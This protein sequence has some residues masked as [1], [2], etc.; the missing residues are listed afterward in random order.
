MEKYSLKNVRQ[1]YSYW[2]KSP[3]MYK[4]ASFVAFF[5]KENFLRENAVAN[6]KLRP[7]DR[8][9]DL[10]C[11]RGYNFS[12]LMDKIGNN[13]MIIGVDYVHEM[14]NV[15]KKRMN[16]KGWD[17]IRIIREDAAK[18]DFPK[19]YFDG[20]ISTLGISAIPDHKEALKRAVYSLK[21]KKRLVILDGKSF[22]GSYKILNPLI[23]CT[24]WSESWDK[25]KNIIT[26][27]K[28]LL[29]DVVIEE[30]SG[31]SFFI[32]TGVKR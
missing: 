24:R 18:I 5:G 32:L 2:G 8:V 20:V 10:A 13:G 3:G 17:S 14:L 9:L 1:V 7:G 22:N 31:G 29:N 25:N 15:A 12:Y 27:A 26:D 19:N 16:E 21:N 30:F 11:G 28:K 4:I 6:L 23:N